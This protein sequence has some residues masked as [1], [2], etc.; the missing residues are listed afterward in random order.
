MIEPI[1]LDFGGEEKGAEKGS[2]PFPTKRSEQVAAGAKAVIQGP[3]G[4]RSVPVENIPVGPGKNVLKKG[5]LIEAIQ[6][7]ARKAKSGDAYL[8]FIPRT[9][10]DIA[11]V[12]CGVSLALD[13]GGNATVAV[14]LNDS[15]T[16]FRIVAVAIDFSDVSLVL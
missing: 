12:G 8:R 7:P 16:A 6:L 11:V 3:K 4:K 1:T 5:E 10:M 15:L 13:A 14:P 2:A 9:E